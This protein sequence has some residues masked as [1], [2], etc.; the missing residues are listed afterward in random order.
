MWGLIIGAI[1]LSLSKRELVKAGI[2]RSCWRSFC[3]V[4]EGA[5][6][7]QTQEVSAWKILRWSGNRYL[8]RNNF[9]DH[10]Y[11]AFGKMFLDDMVIK[12]LSRHQYTVKWYVLF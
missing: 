6:D 11:R 10:Q 8:G 7:S 1:S 5:I 9:S 3:V 12:W 4:A 2:P